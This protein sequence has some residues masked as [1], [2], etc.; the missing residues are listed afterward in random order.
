M[1]WQLVKISSV[2]FS[3]QQTDRNLLDL[4]NFYMEDCHLL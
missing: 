1:F 3:L 2:T 4:S